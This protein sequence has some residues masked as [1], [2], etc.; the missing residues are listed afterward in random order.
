M[1]S[2]EILMQRRAIAVQRALE[3]AQ[4]LD[5]TDEPLQLVKDEPF[6]NDVHVVAEVAHA[7]GRVCLQQRE[8]IVELAGR[9]EALEARLPVEDAAKK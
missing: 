7:L 5:P 9:I 2:T 4:L 8:H 3:C 1:T 6:P